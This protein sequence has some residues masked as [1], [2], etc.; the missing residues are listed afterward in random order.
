MYLNILVAKKSTASIDNRGF[1]SRNEVLA[2]HSDREDCRALPIR[3]SNL[4]S[5]R[6][7][8]SRRL[9]LVAFICAYAPN[10]CTEPDV[11]VLCE[12]E[13]CEDHPSR[14]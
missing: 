13:A 12:R 2:L 14:S 5:A 11:T 6:R 4:C 8:H 10:D 1:A 9:M 7:R 3:L